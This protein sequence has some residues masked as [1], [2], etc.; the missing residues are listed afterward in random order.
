MYLLQL[1]QLH[2]T[3]QVMYL[4]IICGVATPVISDDAIHETA[5]F[6][7]L[8]Y[9]HRLAS[10]Q[11]VLADHHVQYNNC[12]RSDPN[13]ENSIANILQNHQDRDQHEARVIAWTI[14]NR[15]KLK[16]I[17][18]HFSNYVCLLAYVFRQKGHHY[19]DTQD[20]YVR[21]WTKICVNPVAL[22][23]MWA[24]RVTV[25][26][27]CIMP[28]VLDAYWLFCVARSRIAAPL[29]LRSNVP[30]AGTAAIFALLVGWEDAKTAY[31]RLLV[32][33]QEVYDRLVALVTECR[34][35]RWRHGINAKYYGE[36]ATRLDVQPFAPM[37][38]TVA[39][40]YQAVLKM[41][42]YSNQRAYSEKQLVHHYKRILQ[43]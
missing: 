1:K 3:D 4:R 27:H 11:L 12:K 8:A 10:S 19:V 7:L 2:V 14:A 39:G 31:G 22:A 32:G 15:E 6:R 16:H 43:V 20:T 23:T 5:Y 40:V 28:D 13:M 35:H 41:L 34:Y 21:M 17:K 18:Q 33:Q 29:I 37:A 26:L 38:A 25:G 30:C 9:K 36:D 42:H 24:Q